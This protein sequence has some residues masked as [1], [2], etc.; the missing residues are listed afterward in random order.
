MDN[1]I[2]KMIK[3]P[4]SGEQVN[5]IAGG[6]SKVYTYPQLSKFQNINQILGKDGTAIILYQTSDNYGHWVGIIKHRGK[7]EVFDP[8][9]IKPDDELK[10]IDKHYRNE[11]NQHYPHLSYLLYNSPYEIEYNNHKLQK[12]NTNVSTCGR[13]VGAR[14]RMKNIKLDDFARIMKNNKK[15]YDPDYLVTAL[16]NYL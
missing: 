1:K 13:W 11:S 8:L 2:K 16:T 6:K 10:F 14:L 15:G 3:E 9:G 12:D 5:K 7:I 4:L